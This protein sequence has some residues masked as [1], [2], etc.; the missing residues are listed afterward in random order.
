[1]TRVLAVCSLGGTGFKSQVTAIFELYG[2]LGKTRTLRGLTRHGLAVRSQGQLVSKARFQGETTTVAGR[3]QEARELDRTLTYLIAKDWIEHHP[4]GDEA[5]LAH[6]VRE[7]C[8]GLTLSDVA[9]KYAV[10]RAKD[11]GNTHAE[12]WR[13]LLYRSLRAVVLFDFA[14]LACSQLELERLAGTVVLAFRWQLASD[15]EPDAVVPI[16]ECTRRLAENSR[17]TTEF[18]IRLWTVFEAEFNAQLPA[19]KKLPTPKPL[20]D[21]SIFRGQSPTTFTNSYQDTELLSIF[22]RLLQIDP[23]FRL[24]PIKPT[25]YSRQSQVK[26]APGTEPQPASVETQVAP[27]SQVQVIEAAGRATVLSDDGLFATLRQALANTM[28]ALPAPF[29]PQALYATAVPRLYPRR[30]DLYLLG[31]KALN[32]QFPAD[33]F[34]EPSI[35][36]VALLA[37]GL[38]FL[39]QRDYTLAELIA[40]RQSMLVGQ[41]GSG[42]TTLLTRLA[43]LVNTRPLNEGTSPFL[44]L[45]V[46]ADAFVANAVTLKFSTFAAQALHSNGLFPGPSADHLAQQLEQWS[47]MGYLCWGVDNVDERLGDSLETLLVE[48]RRVKACVLALGSTNRPFIRKV[49]TALGNLDTVFALKLFDENRIQQYCERYAALAATNTDNKT[50]EPDDDLAH[51]TSVSRIL[52]AVKANPELAQTPLGLACLCA[53]VENSGI[54]LNASRL[55]ITERVCRAGFKPDAWLN[56]F[57]PASS[58]IHALYRVVRAYWDTYKTLHGAI[59]LSASQIGSWLG[60]SDEAETRRAVVQTIRATRLLIP[61]YQNGAL[62]FS[63]EAVYHCLLA[64]AY[65]DDYERYWGRLMLPQEVNHTFQDELPDEILDIIQEMAYSRHLA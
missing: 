50:S 62:M 52:L 48:A 42:K 7:S 15:L 35:R 53:V 44:M 51:A 30:P 36:C 16:E 5:L 63:H 58:I 11:G 32:P 33:L 19:N 17:S 47:E 39:D 28:A 49:Q 54:L 10:Y 38:T 20:P 1:M 12:T 27:V 57:A 2:R 61:A 65:L 3:S 34:V 46:N 9:P 24:P 40:C 29:D 37:S 31:Q 43:R 14:R 13:Y 22:K 23:G 4:L 59:P 60:P 21:T 55:Y 41:P 25:S 45:V 8:Q 56:T 18:I 6:L 64:L 26:S